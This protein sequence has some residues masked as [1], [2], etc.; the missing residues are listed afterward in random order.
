[1]QLYSGFY[2]YIKKLCNHY[3]TRIFDNKKFRTG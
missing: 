2:G 3:N 1:M